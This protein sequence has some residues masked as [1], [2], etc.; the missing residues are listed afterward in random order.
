MGTLIATALLSKWTLRLLPHCYLQ[1]SFG[2]WIHHFY[3]WKEK[4]KEKQK[5]SSKM[6]LQHQNRL[7]WKLL[8]S[9][10]RDALEKMLKKPPARLEKMWFGSK[11]ENDFTAKDMKTAEEKNKQVIWF[12][13]V[14]FSICFTAWNPLLFT[15]WPNADSLCAGYCQNA[16]NGSKWTVYSSHRFWKAKLIV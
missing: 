1:A 15:N 3:A 10:Q 13:C 8:M 9:L 2:T 7:C 16:I 14:F 6:S 11:E 12:C 5:A 4:K